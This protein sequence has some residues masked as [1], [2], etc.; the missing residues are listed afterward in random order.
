MKSDVEV[1]WNT[2]ACPACNGLVIARFAGRFKSTIELA[3]AGLKADAKSILEVG[4]VVASINKGYQSERVG[5]TASG[6][7][8]KEAMAAMINLFSG[9]LGEEAPVG[10]GAG[11]V[12][13]AGVIGVGA[14]KEGRA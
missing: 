10:H 7:D 8:E 13:E 11:G 5:I 9:G 6:P 3:H 2:E 4:V 1:A 12:C 14:K